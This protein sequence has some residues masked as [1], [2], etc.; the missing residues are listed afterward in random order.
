[1]VAALSAA[2]RLGVL[3]QSPLRRFEITLQQIFLPL[4]PRSGFTLKAEVTGADAA[5]EVD[6]CPAGAR[7]DVRQRVEGRD[8]ARHLSPAVVGHDDPGRPGIHGAGGARRRLVGTA[9]KSV[10]M[11]CAVVACCASAA[12]F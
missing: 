1:M 8:R 7:H 5:V 12:A 10:S 4:L 11:I 6:L 2:A 3:I 9:A